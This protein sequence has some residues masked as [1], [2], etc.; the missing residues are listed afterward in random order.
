M[1]LIFTKLTLIALVCLNCPTVFAAK[2]ACVT[3]EVNFSSRF[4]N[5]QQDYRKY[6]SN[7]NFSKS[8]QPYWKTGTRKKIAYLLHG[9]IGTPYEMK[10]LA[11]LLLK[12]GYTI[13]NDII[14]GHGVNGQISNHYDEVN[15]R[16]HV[17]KSLD[18]LRSCS[19]EISVMGF[20]TGALLIH[21][22]MISNPNFKPQSL[23]FYSPFYKPDLS[24]LS[25]TKDIASLLVPTI[26]VGPIYRLSHYQDIRVAVIDTEHYMQEIPLLT[27]TVIQNLG[28]NVYSKKIL[29]SNIPALLF[30]SE[31]DQVA[32]SEI[33]LKKMKEDFN[34]LSVVW[35]PKKM[36]IPHHLM[37]GTVSIYADQINQKAADFIIRNSKSKIK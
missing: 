26:P 37:V 35:F 23:V 3:A 16:A 9:F 30:T 6:D 2:N 28:S 7:A 24:F 18:E 17:Q 4:E 12:S 1:R 32:D 29:N 34:N 5:L 21:D 15:W 33:S 20:S 19:N 25:W 13:V 27:T 31:N 22:Y 10:P 14:P 11:D 8:N 36:R